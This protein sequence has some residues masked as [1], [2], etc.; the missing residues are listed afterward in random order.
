MG[1]NQRHIP[2]NLRKTSK[3]GTWL[4]RTEPQKQTPT[5]RR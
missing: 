3:G 1:R 2:K 4:S 5:S